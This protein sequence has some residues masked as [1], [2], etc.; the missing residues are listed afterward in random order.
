MLNSLLINVQSAMHSSKSSLREWHHLFTLLLA[1][2]GHTVTQ[3]TKQ[4]G[5]TDVEFMMR[6]VRS[7]SSSN[8][9]RIPA[10]RVK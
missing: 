7:A 10:K 3:G 8:H 2:W 5:K 4:L 6:L 1:C 9:G